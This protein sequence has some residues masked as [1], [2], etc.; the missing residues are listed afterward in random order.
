M[1]DHCTLTDQELSTKVKDW[2]ISLARSGGKT[3]VLQIP[4]NVNEDPD[5][6]IGELLRRFE[7]KRGRSAGVWVKASER[8]P[9]TAG[10]Y[11]V[12]GLNNQGQPVDH[13]DKDKMYYTGN[14]WIIRDGC[15]VTEWLDE[16]ASPGN[17]EMGN[18]FAQWLDKQKTDN[19]YFNIEVWSEE[20]FFEKAFQTWQQSLNKTT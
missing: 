10:Y 18:A 7:D 6:L 20:G 1:N 19:P 11:T 4:A 12:W 14:S 17:K 16:S 2:I 3:W 9:A 15:V 13:S 8:L 5:L